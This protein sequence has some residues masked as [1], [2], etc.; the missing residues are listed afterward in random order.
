[1]LV[2]VSVDGLTQKQSSHSVIHNPQAQDASQRISRRSHTETDSLATVSYTIHRH[3]MLVHVS[4]EGLTHDPQTDSL[5]TVSYTTH[6]H[7]TLVCVSIQ[8]QHNGSTFN[9][10]NST[11]SRLS[12]PASSAQC[13]PGF[14]SITHASL[15][16]QEVVSY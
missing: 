16:F 4:V 11:H 8:R 15:H 10:K 1:M 14:P 12:L 9:L 6:R 2:N 13:Q 5:S 3:K 7:R